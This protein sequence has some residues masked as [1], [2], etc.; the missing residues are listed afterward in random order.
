MQ[1]SRYLNLNECIVHVEICV[2]NVYLQ[3]QV[4]VGD[5]YWFIV[6]NENIMV[7]V[8]EFFIIISHKY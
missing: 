6:V 7:R 8:A 3:A 4:A 2:G 1:I 5:I